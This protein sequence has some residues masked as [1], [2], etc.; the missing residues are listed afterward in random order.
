MAF[1]CVVFYLPYL[2]RYVVED[3][4]VERQYLVN[5]TL[6]IGF[7]AQSL[8]ETVYSQE[9]F[10]ETLLPKLICDWTANYSKPGKMILI[11]SLM[12]YIYDDCMKA[13]SATFFSY[14]RRVTYF[15]MF[16]HVQCFAILF[17]CAFNSRLN[18]S[19]Y[20]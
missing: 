19:P 15:S 1:S 13:L 20:W 17:S 8:D 14:T 10:T 2:C 7:E 4:P 5:M 12:L 3:L 18:I 16:L 11:G 9:I 6:E